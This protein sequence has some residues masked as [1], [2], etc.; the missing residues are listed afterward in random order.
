MSVA[1]WIALGTLD[2]KALGIRNRVP[3]VCCQVLA[4]VEVFP[5]AEMHRDILKSHFVTASL[6]EAMH[7]WSSSY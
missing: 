2:E 6:T 7:P 5:E 1:P 4:S 3:E